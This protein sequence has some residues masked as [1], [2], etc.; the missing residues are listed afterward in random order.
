MTNSEL[1]QYLESLK[2]IPE[3][4]R[5]FHKLK[6]LFKVIEDS[7][8]VNRRNSTDAQVQSGNI[9]WC[10]AFAYTVDVFLY[11]MAEHGYTLQHSSESIDFSRLDE[12]FKKW[13]D[14]DRNLKRKQ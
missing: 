3:E 10:D 9:N 7:I 5:D 6:T 4:F 12:T 2:Y 11:F 13:R 14:Y 1:E 8:V